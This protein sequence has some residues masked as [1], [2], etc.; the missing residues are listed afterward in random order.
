MDVKRYTELK[1]TVDRLQRD[2]DRAEGVLSGLMSRLKQEHDCDTL[3]E[4][5][6]K[7]KQLE[8]K[9]Q[10]AEQRADEALAEFEES[11]GDQLGDSIGG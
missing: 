9:A 7:L 11:Y 2:H 4:A 10:E 1:N 6:A 3:E 8:R 5:K